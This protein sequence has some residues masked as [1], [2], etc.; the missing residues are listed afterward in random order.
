MLPHR[1]PALQT[2]FM[3]IVPVRRS[4]LEAGSLQSHPCPL[5]SVPL[6]ILEM[7]DMLLI[8]HQLVGGY[9]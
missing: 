8:L 5:I 1:D 9:P 7:S 6:P 3:A 2:N 4:L